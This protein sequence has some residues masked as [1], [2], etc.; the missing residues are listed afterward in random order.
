MNNNILDQYK[1]FSLTKEID[2]LD[3]LFAEAVKVV[4]QYDRA[5]ASLIEGGLKGDGS[6]GG[7]GLIKIVG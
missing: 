4:I 2:T 5:S 1:T 3:S 6:R 7:T